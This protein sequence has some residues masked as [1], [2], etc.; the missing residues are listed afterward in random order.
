MASQTNY[1]MVAMFI[2]GMLLFITSMLMATELDENNCGTPKARKLNRGIMVMGI[3]LATSAL[4]YMTCHYRCGCEDADREGTIFMFAGAAL[5]IIVFVLSVMLRTE[6]GDAC[7][8]TKKWTL[9]L[10]A[11]SGGVSLG[12]MGLIGYKAYSGVSSGG[13]KTAAK[14]DDTAA[15]A[16][17][18]AAT[19]AAAAKA[20]QAALQQQVAEAQER[21]KAAKEDEDEVST[22]RAIE[23]LNAKKAA[24][25]EAK[26]ARRSGLLSSSSN[27]SEAMDDSSPRSFSSNTG[28]STVAMPGFGASQVSS[29]SPWGW[30][31]QFTGLKGG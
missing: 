13:G 10:M 17:T 14:K 9:M 24:L 30:N 2:V 18:A 21:V 16:A 5:G 8:S 27:S 1:F 29:G 15:T 31:S 25:K 6:L 4:A 28:Q 19:A 11:L 3:I 22:S 20:E 26:H 12:A 23:E 7:D